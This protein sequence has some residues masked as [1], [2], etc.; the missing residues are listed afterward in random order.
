MNQVR[1]RPDSEVAPG[2][3]G[4]WFLPPRA[5]LTL[6]EAE[7]GL[8]HHWGKRRVTH[9]QTLTKSTFTMEMML[10]PRSVPEAPAPPATAHPR[11]PSSVQE[12]QTLS[13]TPAPRQTASRDW[14]PVSAHV[15]G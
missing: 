4:Y 2:S 1:L 12:V 13:R 11:R 14:A 10:F 7:N 5:P 6:G 3:W 9:D 15:R 8:P